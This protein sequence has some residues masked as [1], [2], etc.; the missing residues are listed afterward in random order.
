MKTIHEITCTFV[1]LTGMAVGAEV[2]LESSN[3][4]TLVSGGYVVSPL[5]L[6]LTNYPGRVI[7]RHGSSGA[8]MDQMLETKQG[9]IYVAVELWH[10]RR[11]EA[12][13][14]V[15][16]KWP[17]AVLRPAIAVAAGNPKSIH[18]LRQ[19]GTTG[20]RVFI[21][22]PGRCQMGAATALLL[23]KNQVVV[24]PAQVT[25]D[26]GGPTMQNLKPF[27][28]QGLLDAAIVWRSSKSCLAPELE[29]VE[30]PAQENIRVNL[31][32]LVPRFSRQPDEALELVRYLASSEA[33]DRWRAFGFEPTAQPRLALR[34]LI[35]RTAG[36]L[37][38]Q[39]KPDS[40]DAITHAT[41]TPMNTY[42]MCNALAAQLEK[43]GVRTTIVDYRDCKDWACLPQDGPPMDIVVLAGP[44]YHSKQP[45][46][47]LT[48]IP[49]LAPVLEAWPKTVFS[50]LIPAWFP[51]T[52]GVA[53]A[54]D[55]DKR[56][57]ALGAQTVMG[58][59]LLTSRGKTPGI[60]RESMQKVLANFVDNLV[61][62]RRLVHKD[63]SSVLLNA[64]C[65]A[66]P[67][68]GTL[69]HGSVVIGK[70]SQGIYP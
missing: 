36:V 16:V 55:T 63:A 14:I 35:V 51:E 7:Y 25:L 61:H 60:D 41:T 20:L 27:F 26:G 6:L 59:S 47:L 2:P 15:A 12:E 32:A 8:M 40:V 54:K 53:T 46:Q 49:K 11:A 66:L 42:V 21:E 57:A 22:Q 38:D 18:G 17:L 13:D 56:L 5:S 30:I 33:A 9:D 34:A 37:P 24:K 23:A 50:A 10:V 58:V 1:L 28:K 64:R 31:V 44:S 19:L 39:K 70:R 45:E 67:G 62:K 48:L 43:R 52:K 68:K 69:S 4:V 29:L 65:V 3:T